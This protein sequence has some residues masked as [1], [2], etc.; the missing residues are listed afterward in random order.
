MNQGLS[1]PVQ[2]APQAGRLPGDGRRVGRAFWVM[3]Q[4]VVVMAACVDVLLFILFHLLDSPFLAWMNVA[5]VA[6]YAV[7]Y[8]LLQRRRNVLALVL[9]WA[10]VLG[11]AAIGTMLIGWGA[12]FHYY[13][14]MFIP[15]IVVSNAPRRQAVCLVLLL[16]AFYL[17]LDMA[18][19]AYGPWTPLNRWGV[20]VVNAFNVS[21]V[22]A[23]FSYVAHVYRNAVVHAEQR[24]HELATRDSLTGLSNRRHFLAL[25]EHAM[26]RAHRH[27]RPLALVLID[28][29]HFKQINDIHGHDAGDKVLVRVGELLRRTCREE[30]IVARWGG[31]EFLLML[32]DNDHAGAQKLAERFRI[33]AQ[34]QRLTLDL[35]APDA[36]IT[37]QGISF[38]VSLGV[39]EVLP[40]EA[41]ND[42]IARSD[43][44]LYSAKTGG[45][46]RVVVV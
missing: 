43:K 35:R 19:E 4:R 15:A 44:A 7:A 46:N 28:I 3:V 22:F 9:I 13:L 5:S 33:V 20:H 36:V 32:P 12:G 16:L 41:L 38:T 24:L 2:A 23:M 31:E 37:E 25:A 27:K 45:R 21:I 30:D 29:D 11:H 17:G 1:S 34:D 26:A 40:Y 18:A 14:M 8:A 39:T 6:I 10:E 42:A